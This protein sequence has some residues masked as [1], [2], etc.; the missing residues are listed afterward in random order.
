MK[1]GIIGSMQLT[2]KML[3]V[4]DQLRERGLD[5]YVTSLHQAFIGKNDEEKE[6]IKL[7]QKNNQDAI[8]EFW[9]M[10]QGGDAVLALNLKKNGIPNYIGGNTFL[11]LG[12]AH[13]LGQTIYLWNPIPENPIYATEIIAMKPIIIYGDLEKIR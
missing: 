9:R 13:V 8:C 2:E 4:R 5:A 3:E 12:F 1:I 7:E 6:R 11:E 10:M